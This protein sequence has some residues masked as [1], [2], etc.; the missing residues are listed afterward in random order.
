[1]VIVHALLYKCIRKLTALTQLST[2]NKQTDPMARSADAHFRNKDMKAEADE[3]IY[4]K[5][6]MR[7]AKAGQP[8]EV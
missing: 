3:V 5:N 8:L 7:R 6:K 4:G 2:G 1:M